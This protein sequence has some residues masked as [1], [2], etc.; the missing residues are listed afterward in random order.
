MPSQR[1]T[2]STAASPA[3]CDMMPAPAVFKRDAHQVS[4]LARE[5]PSSLDAAAEVHQL[6]RTQEAGAAVKLV[7]YEALQLRAILRVL[8]RVHCWRGEVAADQVLALCNTCV[9]A[10][11]RRMCIRTGITRRRQP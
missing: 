2:N 7:L 3:K 5:A 4:L 11:V 1:A 9:C 10:S 8:Q 6:Q